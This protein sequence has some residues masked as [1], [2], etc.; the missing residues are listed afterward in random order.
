[1]TIPR[2]PL[3]QRACVQLEK[4]IVVVMKVQRAALS[5]DPVAAFAHLYSQVLQ[6]IREDFIVGIAN[7][8]SNVVIGLLWRRF[9]FHDRDP[10]SANQKEPF[11][12]D[13]KS[14]V[15]TGVNF[16]S[17]KNGLQKRLH[18]IQ[19]ADNECDMAEAFNYAAGLRNAVMIA[20]NGVVM[21]SRSVAV[22]RNK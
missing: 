18:A 22:A 20:G 6:A 9:A 11:P 21:H 13:R 15:A 8:E 1:M 2:Q 19:I 5:A 14:L 12:R 7:L 3:F 10:E 17:A 16:R 4:V